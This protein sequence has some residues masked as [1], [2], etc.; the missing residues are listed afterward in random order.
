MGCRD[1]QRELEREKKRGGERGRWGE[2]KER[3]KAREG[4]R[5]KIKKDR[6]TRP[7]LAVEEAHG[8]NES[9]TP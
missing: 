7:R 4:K 3:E 2:E 6:H 8:S 1:R 5:E 9:R